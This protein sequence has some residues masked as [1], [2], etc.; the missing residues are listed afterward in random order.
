MSLPVSNVVFNLR[1]KLNADQ[2]NLLAKFKL[3]VETE[4]DFYGRT[5][6][7]FLV[8]FLRSCDFDLELSKKTLRSYYLVRVKYPQWWANRDIHH[9]QVQFLIQNKLA[10]MLS[11]H[12]DR[13][14]PTI[15]I[16]HVARYGPDPSILGPG[17]MLTTCAL[18]TIAKQTNVQLNG[19]IFIFDMENYHSWMFWRSFWPSLVRDM[20]NSFLYCLP[21]KVQMM[22][23][24]NVPP[25]TYAAVN[26]VRS[27][28]PQAYKDKLKCCR[29]WSDIGKLILIELLPDEYGGQ[30]GP[31]KVHEDETAE[32]GWAMSDYILDDN[33]YGFQIGGKP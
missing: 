13:D 6:E 24:V 32:K 12:A 17:G 8:L 26:F 1:L 31:V 2:A 14:Y 33:K 16:L 11:D 21:M 30:A 7:D 27:F 22:V 4:A 25:M 20:L 19:V 23:L 29:S 10:V 9:P 3:W 18:D 15:V 28:L 5:D